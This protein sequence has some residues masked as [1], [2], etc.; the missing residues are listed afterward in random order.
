[1]IKG[2]PSYPFHTVALAV[3][4]NSELSFLVAELKRI[5]E[6]HA[7][8]AIFIH[9]GK[10]TGEKFRELSSV[11]NQHGFHDGNSRIYWEQGSPANAILQICRHEVV[12]LLI[13]GLSERSGFSLPVGS[14]TAE[15]SQKAKCTLLVYGKETAGFNR[16]YVDALDHRKTDHTLMTAIYFGERMKAKEMVVLDAAQRY[17]TL[18]SSLNVYPQS[19]ESEGEFSMAVDRSG[20]DIT[21]LAGQENK[22]KDIL[23]LAQEGKADLIVINSIDHHLKIFDRISNDQ[24]GKVLSELNCNLMIVHSRLKEE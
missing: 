18:N 20:V 16:V 3:A 15:L 12:D 4:F 13:V 2:K 6:S 5:S 17:E 1:M 23:T 10:R 24:I 19:A 21:I 11:M 9:A 8:M 7:S 22:L 14:L